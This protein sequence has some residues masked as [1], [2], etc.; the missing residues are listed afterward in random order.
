VCSQL[1]EGCCSTAL[2]RLFEKASDDNFLKPTKQLL[3]NEDGSAQPQLHM[4]LMRTLQPDAAAYIIGGGGTP[5]QPCL[6]RS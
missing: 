5:S 1:A 4:L 2:A 3:S 6:T